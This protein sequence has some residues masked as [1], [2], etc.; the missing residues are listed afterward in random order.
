MSKID[1]KKEF[2]ALYLPSAKE[3][4]S[5]DVPSMNFLMIDGMGD[6]NKS[7]D[8]QDAIEALYSVSYTI[9][10]M[11]KKGKIGHD[12]GVM[13]LEGLWWA[14]DM[15]DFL[16]MKK[17]LWRWTAMIMQPDFITREMY[18]QASD[19]AGKKK[20]LPALSK[21]RFENFHEGKSAQ[22]L[23]IGSFAAEGPT[24]K[25]IHDYITASGHKL[26]D[27]HHEIYL[28]DFRRAAPE[29]LK[30]IIRQPFE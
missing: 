1:F 15:A 23:Y 21:M 11:I 4:V 13:P 28:S 20:E 14:D 24:I 8:Y 6:P 25:K 12:Y 26:R 10:F 27:K 19:E 9:K 18:E 16:K 17:D 29:K 2:K 22:I 3:V 30:T 7:K 5:V